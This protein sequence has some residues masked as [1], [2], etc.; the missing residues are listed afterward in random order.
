MHKEENDNIKQLDEI[1]K[2]VTEKR[3]KI[4]ED[5]S[6]AYMASKADCN[7]EEL[8]CTE[9]IELV[10]QINSPTEVVY[11]FRKKT[12]EELSAVSSCLCNKPVT[13]E[14]K[15]E[16]A[17][18]WENQ[19][20]DFLLDNNISVNYPELEGAF[21][22]FIRPLLQS[23]REEVWKEEF[24]KRGL[25]AEA[26]KRETQEKLIEMMRDV[27][28]SMDSMNYTDA[29]YRANYMSEVTIRLKQEKKIQSL[30]G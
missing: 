1:I 3:A 10:E 5:F 25:L 16:I 8:L 24:R 18:E 20:A 15:A 29:Q 22:K 6:R 14:K 17:E 12:E 9:S 30:K 7:L 28:D 11:F 21:W 27:H 2:R 13:E 26:V 19:V 23:A 4:L